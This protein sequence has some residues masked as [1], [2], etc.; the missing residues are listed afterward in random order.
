MARPTT[1]KATVPSLWRMLR[2]FWPYTK[3]YCLLIAGSFFALFAAA[4][5]RTLEPWPL[6]FVFD[7]IIMPSSTSESSNWASLKILDPFI[8]LIITAVGLILII[9]LRALMTYYNRVGFALVGNRVLTEVRTDLYKHLQCL[10]LSFHSKARSGDLITRVIGDIGLLKDAVVTALMPLIGNALILSLMLGMMFW[11]HWKLTLIV[12]LTLPLYWLPSVHLG[13]KIRDVSRKQR[14][15]EG[16]IASNTAEVMGAIKVVQAL[17]LEETFS[18]AFSSQ[19]Q[20]SLKEGVKAKRLAAHLQGTVQVMIA[21]STALVLWYGTRLVLL[22]QLTPGSL[23]VFLSYL[24]GAF[25]PMQDFAKYTSRLAKAAAAGERV[26]DIFEKKLEI[27]NKPTAITAPALNGVVQFDKVSFAYEQ[28]QLILN[29]LSFNAKP[30]QRVAIVGTSGNGKSTLLSLISRLY[31]PS[32]GRVL[33]DGQDIRDYTLE[34]LRQQISVVLQ[35]NLLFA[36]SI[37]DNI[38]FGATKVSGEDIENAARLANAHDFIV[39]FPEGYDT[40]VGERGITLSAGQRQRIAIAR[41]AIRKAPIIILDEPTTGLDEANEQAV[42]EALEKLAQNSTTFLVT[43]NL[44]HAARADF[45][46]FLDHGRILEQGTHE[47]LLR[48]DKLYAKLYYL[49]AQTRPNG[50]KEGTYSYAH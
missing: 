17:S 8:I 24:K 23:L 13:R 47:E 12:L 21:L 37:R 26:L 15:R 2:Y 25:K 19:N 36:G 32:S 1:L 45:I 48:L 41:A 14:K 38:A 50:G 3:K 16:A 49:E 20:K 11:L 42:I 34:S 27:V 43:H 39:K 40:E 9:G 18:K 6:K 7:L 46:I 44:K 33:I 5:F 4:I 10:S 30:K 22:G 35:D 29:E 28:D 31:E